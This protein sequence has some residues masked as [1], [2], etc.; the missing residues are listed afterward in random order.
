MSEEETSSNNKRRSARI[1]GIEIIEDEKGEPTMIKIDKKYL[2][3]NGR[4]INS[5]HNI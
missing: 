1:K 5:T 3:S 4:M 2:M